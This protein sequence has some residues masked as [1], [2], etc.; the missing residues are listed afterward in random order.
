MIPL[1]TT[2]KNGKTQEKA[3]RK[4]KINYNYRIS[5]FTLCFHPFFFKQQRGD[6]FSN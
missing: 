5:K 2:Q 4:V 6:H 1:D 3:K